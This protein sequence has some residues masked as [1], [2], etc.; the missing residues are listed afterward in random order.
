VTR[1]ERPVRWGLIVT[2]AVAVIL[3]VWAMVA[4][5][6]SAVGFPTSVFALPRWVLVHPGTMLGLLVLGSE[7]GGAHATDRVERALTWLARALAL[8]SVFVLANVDEVV[9][10]NFIDRAA[11]HSALLRDLQRVWI[12]LSALFLVAIVRRRDL[13]RSLGAGSMVATV[14]F[15]TLGPT[16][17]APV[18]VARARETLGA[19]A[20][21][22]LAYPIVLAAFATALAWVRGRPSKTARWLRLLLI[23]MVLVAWWIG[24]IGH[25]LDFAGRRDGTAASQPMLRFMAGAAGPLLALLVAATWADEPSPESSAT[26]PFG[27]KLLG[28]TLAAVSFCFVIVGGALRAFEPNVGPLAELACGLLTLIGIGVGAQGMAL[29]EPLGKW[30]LGTRSERMLGLALRLAIGLALAVNLVA[31]L[32]ASGK[33]AAAPDLAPLAASSGGLDLDGGGL[34]VSVEPRPAASNPS[35]SRGCVMIVFDETAGDTCEIDIGYTSEPTKESCWPLQTTLDPSRRVVYVREARLLSAPR[36]GAY[37]LPGCHSTTTAIWTNRRGRLQRTPNAWLAA[38]WTGLVL[39]LAA[40][41]ARSRRSPH[42]VGALPKG[43]GETP[44]GS[45]YRTGDPVRAGVSSAADA[46][47]AAPDR[48]QRRAVFVEVAGLLIVLAVTAPVVVALLAA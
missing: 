35:A 10:S 26:G 11:D 40:A 1:R 29:A 3:L 34:H 25:V 47:P 33:A 38:A 22:L 19:G 46:L 14:A 4:R 23:P 15:V 48:S 5:A 21:L 24:G 42:L 12:A 16:V 41:A 8:S 13:A 7:L 45:V 9:A 17:L 27:T 30:L 36:E 44:R 32:R 37:Q 18:V 39:A 2:I 28:A 6:L 31:T 20:G 43:D